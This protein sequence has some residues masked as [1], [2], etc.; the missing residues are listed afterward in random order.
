MGPMLAIAQGHTNVRSVAAHTRASITWIPTKTAITAIPHTVVASVSRFTVP[1]K[2][3]SGISARIAALRRAAR[4][5]K[6]ARN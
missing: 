4:Q 1:E 5:Q 2:T 6:L 3:I